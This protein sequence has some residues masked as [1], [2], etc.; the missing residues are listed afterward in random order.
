MRKMV[1]L[2]CLEGTVCK[3]RFVGCV[4]WKRAIYEDMLDQNNGR[5]TGRDMERGKRRG[6]GKTCIIGI[7]IVWTP[8]PFKLSTVCGQEYPRAVFRDKL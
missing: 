6:G 7:W 4:E 3:L 8:S 1:L 5:K 2:E